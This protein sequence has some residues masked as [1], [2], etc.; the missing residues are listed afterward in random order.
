MEYAQRCDE[1]LGNLTI[2]EQKILNKLKIFSLLG[3]A[4]SAEFVITVIKN[5]AD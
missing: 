4:M 1:L 2:E 5:N 3:Y